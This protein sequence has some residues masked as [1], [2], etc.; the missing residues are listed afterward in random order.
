[1]K[2]FTGCWPLPRWRWLDGC[3]SAQ[4]PAD[5]RMSGGALCAVSDFDAPI[6]RRR[7]R[8][9]HRRRVTVTA[10]ATRSA[11]RHRRCCRHEVYAVLRD[12]GFSPLG[13]P[14]LRGYV[15]TIAVIDRGGEDGRLVIDARNGRIIRFMPAADAYGMAP[16][17]EAAV[18]LR[19]T[20]PQSA[21]PPPTVVRA[22]RRARR[23]SIP[24]V[25][26]RTV[27][28]PKAAPHARQTPVAA[29]AGRARRAACPGAQRQPTQPT[30]AVQPKPAAAAAAGN[31]GQAKPARDDPADPGDAAGAGAGVGG[32]IALGDAL[33]QNKSAPEARGVF[34]CANVS[35]YSA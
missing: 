2:F 31:V 12:N 33:I 7:T 27:P 25:A 1:M 10:M 18:R 35:L 5:A 30:A 19:L 23:A 29:Q 9:R 8:C 17:Y 3:A 16:A 22:A 21:L 20:G 26:S 28:L 15:Y 14:R 24:H 34:H 32:W 13:I 11:A 4:V 6:R